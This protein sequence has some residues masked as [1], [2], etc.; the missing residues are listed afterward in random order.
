MKKMLLLLFACRLLTLGAVEPAL[1]IVYDSDYYAPLVSTVKLDILRSDEVSGDVILQVFLENDDDTHFD[2][3]VTIPAG[4]S[5]SSI[6]F[7]CMNSP[8]AIDS[9]KASQKMGVGFTL[10]YGKFFQS[11]LFTMPRQDVDIWIQ[12]K[13]ILVFNQKHTIVQMKKHN[14]TFGPPPPGVKRRFL[15]HGYSAETPELNWKLSIIWH[16]KQPSDRKIYADAREL[17]NHPLLTNA[18]D[19]RQDKQEL[20]KVDLELNWLFSEAER[21]F[22]Q[23]KLSVEQL[24]QIRIHRIAIQKSLEG[25]ENAQ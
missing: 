9:V 23:G 14:K 7:Y 4:A 11:E 5:K 20:R 6:Y 3:V 15:V 19:L 17:M 22:K 18:I 12:E 24:N 16:A 2:Q 25:K 10:R 1:N 8:S 13:S 21:L